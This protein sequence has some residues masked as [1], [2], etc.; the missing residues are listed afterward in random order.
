MSSNIRTFVPSRTTCTFFSVLGC[1]NMVTVWVKIMFGLKW[2]L[3]YGQGTFV[4][5]VAIINTWLRSRSGRGHAFQKYTDSVLFCSR[6]NHYGCLKSS[7]I[8]FVSWN[9]VQWWWQ[10]NM[11]DSSKKAGNFSSSSCST[12]LQLFIGKMFMGFPVI[13]V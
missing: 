10:R 12:S 5:M 2:L 7:S 1:G 3:C 9:W 8:K 4:C 11:L 13:R 6:H